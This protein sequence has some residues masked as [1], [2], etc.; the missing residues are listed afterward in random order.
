MKQGKRRN[1]KDALLWP[2]SQEGDG[3][4]LLRCQRSK[5]NHPRHLTEGWE[6]GAFPFLNCRFLDVPWGS[7]V[8]SGSWE[9]VYFSEGESVC[10]TLVKGGASWLPDIPLGDKLLMGR[11]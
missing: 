2:L 6:S 11:Y 7:R 9:G 1:K 5:E 4:I 10:F 8:H 3:S